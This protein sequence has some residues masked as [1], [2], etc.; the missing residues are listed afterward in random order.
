MDF[1]SR[2]VAPLSPA[3]TAERGFAAILVAANFLTLAPGILV[4]EEIANA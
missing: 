1:P 2:L 4:W 3:R